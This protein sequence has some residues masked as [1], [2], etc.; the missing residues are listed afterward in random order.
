MSLCPRCYAHHSPE[1]A[2]SL[3]N[4]SRSRPTARTRAVDYFEGCSVPSG[5]FSPKG[6][7]DIAIGDIGGVQ[8]SAMPS[9]ARSEFYAGLL[10]IEPTAEPSPVRPPVIENDPFP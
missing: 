10:P 8:M 6:S 9:P 4:V 1:A 5:G 2:D 3:S 7:P